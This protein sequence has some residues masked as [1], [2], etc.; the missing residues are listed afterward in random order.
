[1]DRNEVLYNCKSLVSTWFYSLKNVSG[2]YIELSNE[3]EN[4][5]V[6]ADFDSCADIIADLLINNKNKYTLLKLNGS[7]NGEIKNIGSIDI[8]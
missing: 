7:V 2:L 6:D 1:M 5:R 4:E 8:L 3:S